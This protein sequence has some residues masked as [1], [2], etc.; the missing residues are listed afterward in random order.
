MPVSALQ[1]AK[2]V[3]HAGSG[4]V[5][6]WPAP[7]VV[8]HSWCAG[9]LCDACLARFAAP[10][11]RCARC[12]LRLAEANSPCGTCSQHTPPM[13]RTVVALDYAFPWDRL[14]ARF[15][16]AQA[17]ELAGVLAHTLIGP[18]AQPLAGHGARP[19]LV[20]PVP[21][22]PRRL[23]E[24]GYNQAWELARR[25]AQALDLPAQPDGLQRWRDTP[26]QSTLDAAARRANLRDAFLIHPRLAKQ[27]AGCH[28]ALV[29]DVM[30]TGATLATAAEL[31]L[32]SGAREVSAWVLARTP[33]PSPATSPAR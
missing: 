17:P 8:C 2:S 12:G 29:D 33:A 21:L 11:P 10:Q 32:R 22:S 31:L 16:F 9:G 7:C 15:K 26:A 25:L 27:L 19:D 28:V 13:A 1:L 3:A 5:R 18:L 30:T 20:L 4:W 23:R 24:R 14:I 6:R